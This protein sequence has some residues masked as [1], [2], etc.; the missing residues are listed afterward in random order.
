MTS[1][2]SLRG[3]KRARN[4]RALAEI[5]LTLSRERG[6]DN[7]TVA[8]IAEKAELSRRTF[9][10]YFSCKEEAIAD[11]LIQRAQD[12]LDTWEAPDESDLIGLVRSLV[13]HQMQS[14][15]HEIFPQIAELAATSST[16]SAY[17]QTAT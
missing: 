16:L 10:N 8:E 12:G 14:G 9:S 2:S 5:T 3:R 1:T 13:L 4:R 17:A 15:L 6:L 7:V 11:V